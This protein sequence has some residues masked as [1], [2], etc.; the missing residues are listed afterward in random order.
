VVDQPGCTYHVSPTTGSFIRKADGALVNV[1][2]Q[3]GCRWTVSVDADWLSV[4]RTCVQ[5]GAQCV[6]T[7]DPTGAT[8][9]GAFN[10]NVLAYDAPLAPGLR[11]ARIMVRWNTPTLG[12]NVAVTQASDCVVGLSPQAVSIGAA[13]GSVHIFAL[14]PNPLGNNDPWQVTSK[15]DWITL[16]SPAD[17]VWQQGDGDV[18]FNVAAN[19]GSSARVGTVVACGVSTTTVTQAGLAPSWFP[20]I[21]LS[22][23]PRNQRR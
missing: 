8:G 21:D 23:H 18:H 22:P 12:Q 3:D 19:A 11:K 6:T 13:G 16:T 15:A 5:V 2:T 14:T 20:A 1:T 4:S 10:Y 9:T 7:N 17:G